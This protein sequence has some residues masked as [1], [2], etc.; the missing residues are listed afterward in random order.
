M[1]EM[2]YW[3]L[4]LILVMGQITVKAQEEQIND[5]PPCGLTEY[6]IPN[7]L[8][9]F[10]MNPNSYLQYRNGNNL[11]KIPLTINL[12]AQA[13]GS[14]R[15]TIPE[16]VEAMCQL[17]TLY[18]EHN[19]R[20]FIKGDIRMPNN[21]SWYN[22]TT[23]NVGA[24]MYNATKVANT[25]N[26]YIDNNAAGNCGYAY[27]GGDGMFLRKSCTRG[28]TSTTWAHEM[29]HSLS[30][31]HT[32][33]GWEGT[34][35]NPNQNTPVVVTGTGNVVQVERVDRTNCTTAADGFCDTE[36]DYISERWSCNAQ[37][38]SNVMKDPAGAEF[39]AF[40]K[41]IMAYANDACANE[42][43]PN[44]VSA[45]RTH[46]QASKA[47]FLFNGDLPDMGSQTATV[48]E[49]VADQ[50]VH[51]QNIRLTW[52]SVENADQYIVQVARFSDFGQREF[53]AFIQDTTVIVPA[54]TENRNYFYRVMPF[55]KTDFCVK[56]SDPIRFS[57]VV[58]TSTIDLQGNSFRIYPTILTEGQEF[59]V[60]G[61]LNRPLDVKF[62]L[63]D[64]HGRVL[65]RYQRFILSG[66]FRERLPVGTL[67]PGVYLLRV[68]SDA[69]SS[70][71]KFV[72][73]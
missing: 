59:N 51:Y 61:L 64:T 69:G 72:V 39:R 35:Y 23:N 9:E 66:N 44:Q 27:L 48:L 60:E 42:F 54:L 13:D 14:G 70:T 29:G 50:A 33:Y 38:Q 28:T 47:N 34:T 8:R 25:I 40:G 5:I 73:Q 65:N 41:Y 18:A 17:N 56:F 24:A 1:K 30:L 58:Q 2:K 21:T 16:L 10:Q 52:N 68:S 57:T 26:V 55:N 4:A 67:T 45:M 71:L 36:P 6:S 43:S 11:L 31:P 15:F 12:V 20:F 63:M 19:I 62:D 7:W 32:F 49:P 22:H 46:I 37:G 3:L 53:E